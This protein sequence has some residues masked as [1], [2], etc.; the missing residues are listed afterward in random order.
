MKKLLLSL[1]LLSAF[2]FGSLGAENVMLSDNATLPF[3]INVQSSSENQTIIEYNIGYFS[4]KDVRINGETYYELSLGKEANLFDAGNPALPKISR[5]VMIG[6][7]AKMEVELISSAYTDYRM[8]IAPSKGTIL[9]TVDP[10]NVAYSFRDTYTTNAFYPNKS[11]DLTEPFIL[12]DFRGTTLTVYPFVY[13]PVTKVLRVYHNMVVKMTK[14]G[15][16]NINIRNTRTSSYSRYFETIYQNQ[17]LNFRQFTDRYPVTDEHGKMLVICHTNFLSAIQPFV[18][19]KNQKGIPTEL[20]EMS[21][22][23]TTASVL[24][25]YIQTRY[26]QDPELTF[27]QLVGDA[28]QIPTLMSGGGGSD[29]SFA[30]VAG[31][32]SY[33]DIF[34]GRFSAEN[35]NH[36]NTQVNRTLY[37]EKDMIEGAWLKKGMGIASSQGPGDDNENDNVHID[38]IRAD[39]LGYGY[40]S[41][42]QIYDTNGGT[43]GMVTTGLNE[44]RS[45]ISYCGHG[46]DTSWGT[47]GY[48]N[49]N[50]NALVNDNKLPFILS[51]AC[52]NG[53]FTSTTCFAEAWMRAVNETTG[54]PN[55]AI[56][57]YMSSI[58]QSWNPPMAGE[59][60][61][62]DLLVQD[63][64]NTFGGICYN[65]SSKM[66]EQYGADGISMYKTWII[67]GDASV[68]LRTDIPQPLVLDYPTT[69]LVGQ[70]SLLVNGSEV[71]LLVCLSDT[72]TN[73]II[74][75]GYTDETGTITLTFAPFTIPQYVRLTVSGYNKITTQSLIQVIPS[76][77][78]YV[79]CGSP[80]Y[81]DIPTYN[82]SLSFG[83]NF[84][85]I[86]SVI[87][88]N[89]VATIS[90]TDPYITII[91]S[92][93]TIGNIAANGTINLENIFSFSTAANI[94]DQHSAA[95]HL[96]LQSATNVW[97]Y[98][99]NI[100]INAPAFTFGSL[101][102][103]D[104][105]GNNN[106]RLESGEIAVL[107]IPVQNTGH[108]LSQNTNLNIYC[109]S[110]QIT[111]TPVQ[112]DLGELAVDQIINALYE[113]IISADAPQAIQVPLALCLLSGTYQSN[114]IITL[115]INLPVE[116]FETNAFASFPWQ[117]AGNS[118]WSIVD[119]DPFEGQYSAKSGTI[120]HNQTSVISVLMDIPAATQIKFYKKVSSEPNYDK[121]KF[122]I[123]NSLKGEWSGEVAW[124]QESY[125][126]TAGSHTFKWTYAKDSMVSEG[127]D[128]A[129]IDMIQFIAPGQTNPAPLIAVSADTIDFGNVYVDSTYYSDFTIGNFGNVELTGQILAPDGFTVSEI[130]ARTLNQ[131]MDYLVPI[132]TMKTYRLAFNPVAN[133]NYDGNMIISS[134]DVLAG[135]K[136][137]ALLAE[138]TQGNNPNIDGPVT[139]LKGNY[140]NPFNP[141][142]KINFSLA[143]AEKVNLS[144]YNI[145][146]QKV[147]TLIDENKPQG[148]HSVAWNGLDS[149]AKKVGS[150]VYFYKL[151]A[152]K[153]SSIKKMILLK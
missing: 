104:D 152:G 74:A 46:S 145:K 147:L 29:P 1:V 101:Q 50:V 135:D 45:V 78:A 39:L 127:S 25:T 103:Q 153:Y 81:Q 102:I 131:R 58:N 33:P 97:E 113:V 118:N 138:V 105:G 109:S 126:V 80:V 62:I 49:T 112:S 77:G 149:Q 41:V 86:G 10:E 94:A 99:C 38:N 60:E 7:D 15:T 124:T 107:I 89:V 66:I 119:V 12:R 134:N 150:G 137:V 82:S 3:K 17:F 67:F 69:L 148:S 72:T 76:E 40:T 28:P 57:A 54:A 151:E 79:V 75:S 115:A 8:M 24:K 117:F 91:D 136:I 68:Q 122:N 116:S 4:K 27:V 92:T 111:L 121:L 53:N 144:I 84:E 9:R 13:N 100:I 31:T 16:D 90:S 48:S 42:D 26:T 95:I 19:W 61:M 129:W 36:V 98:N 133:Q 44:G 88:E 32:D 108:A 65:G 73:Q 14:T 22:I 34:I 55:G 125:D 56:G 106:G 130:N 59:D 146:G 30:L 87:A 47:T 110:P 64:K 20:V 6:N 23:G 93:E 35:V 139:T 52:V 18:N 120:N 96:S 143:K 51:V 2:L 85:N 140:P 83:F 21:T 128:C 114:Q 37:Y 70:S 71:G 123:D 5:N 141:A 132:G 63:Q 43:A 142:T 11:A